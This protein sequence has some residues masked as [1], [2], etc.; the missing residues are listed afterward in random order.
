MSIG[1]SIDYKGVPYYQAQLNEFVRTY[2]T[3]FNKIHNAAEDL[4]GQKGMDFFNGKSAVTGKNYELYEEIKSFS[5]NGTAEGK[6]GAKTVTSYYNVT[7][8]NFCV[9]DEIKD[10]VM[11]FALASDIDKGVDC[12]DMLDQIIAGK[13]DKSMFK[14]GT[15][16]EFLSTFTANI[17]IDT[18]QASLFATSQSNI[19]KAIDEQ[20]MS[21]SSVD[22]DE[23]AMNMVKYRSAYELSAKMIST[24]SQIY[25][26]LLNM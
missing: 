21:I 10:N 17:G 3:S 2:A 12:V 20:R 16:M 26:V 5:S 22:S 14:Q 7:A 15:P 18:Q 4:S 19:T 24:M 25:D 23:E 6:D 9:T 1:S 8:L 13:T 11:K